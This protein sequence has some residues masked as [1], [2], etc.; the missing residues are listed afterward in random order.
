M[1]TDRKK[2]KKWDIDVRNAL[3]AVVSDC[4]QVLGCGVTS[5]EGRDK[6]IIKRKRGNA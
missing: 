2:K 6:F 4:H 5:W 1:K 3:C